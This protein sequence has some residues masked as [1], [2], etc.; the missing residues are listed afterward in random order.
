MI[1]HF[2]ITPLMLLLF[3][4]I[5]SASTTIQSTTDQHATVLSSTAQKLTIA[6]NTTDLDQQEVFL[7]EGAVDSFTIS[8]EGITYEYG[9]PVLPGVSRFVVVPPR[10]GLELIVNAGESRRIRADHQPV[11]CR[12]ENIAPLDR[13]RAPDDE[14][15]GLY[16]AV[17]AEMTEPLVIRGVRVVKVTTYPLQYDSDAGEYIH[18]PHIETE[19]RFTDDQPV[20]PVEYP[21]RRNRSRQFLRFIREL[22]INGN[23][24][25]RDDPDRDSEP[26]YVGH[27]LIVTHE[28][29]LEYAAPFIE[30][31]RKAGYKVDIFRVSTENALNAGIVSQA[32]QERY[33]AY[34]EDGSDP[35]EYILLIG[36]R[37]SYQFGPAAQWVLQAPNNRSDHLYACLEGNDDYPDVAISRWPSG[38][39]ET[40]ELAVGRTLAY[41]AEPFMED[42]AWFNRVAAYSQHWGYRGPDDNWEPSLHSNVRWGEEVLK[43]IGYQDIRFYETYEWDPRGELIG[44]YIRDLMNEGTN[45]HIGR[46]E[47][48]YFCDWQYG[49]RANFDEEVNDN[50]VFPIELGMC[51]HGERPRDL[52]FRTGSGE[53]LKGYV[54]TTYCWYTPPTLPMNVI[55]LELVRGVML[56]DLPLGWGFSLAITAW[57]GYMSD[58]LWGN[59]SAYLWVKNNC[60][61]LGDPAIQPWLG[62]PRVLDFE[63]PAVISSDDRVVEVHVFDPENDNADVKGAQVSLYA[64]G[65]IPEPDDEGYADYDGMFMVTKETDGAGLARFVFD[66]DASFEG[67]DVVYVTITGRDILPLFSEIEVGEPDEAVEIGEYTLVE[68]EGNDDGEVNPGEQFTLELTARNSGSMRLADVRGVV[69]SLS[70]W[71]EVQEN[72]IDFDGIDPGEEVG[73]EGEINLIISPLCPDG[74]SRPVT[75]PDLLVEFSDEDNSW[76]SGIRLNPVAPNLVVRQVVGGNVIPAG[77][78]EIDIE[79]ENVGGMDSPAL[80]AE[81]ISEG[82]D[83]LV[84]IDGHTGYGRV[85]SGR[86]ARI[87]GDC[88]IVTSNRMFIPGTRSD[89]LL[90]LRTEDGFVDSARFYLQTEEPRENAPQSPDNYGYICFDDTDDDWDMAPEYNWVEISPVDDDRDY[91]GTRIGFEGH[92]PRDMGESMVVELNMTTQFYGHEYDRITVATNGFIVMG[93]QE[94]IRNYQNWPLDRGIGGGLGMVAPFWDDLRFA[95]NS[96]VYYYLDQEEHRFIIEWYRLSHA[97][98]DNNLTFELM[99]YDKNFWITPTGDPMILFQYKTISNRPNVRE[100]DLEWENNT[101]YASVGISSPDEPTGISYTWKNEYPVTSAPLENRRAILFATSVMDF[102]AG[103]LYGRITDAATGEPIIGVAVTTDYGYHA[104]SDSVGYWSIG[105]AA[106]EVPFSITT[107]CHGYNNSTIAGLELAVDDTLEVNLALLHPEFH[108]SVQNIAMRLAPEDSSEFEFDIENRGNGELDWQAIKKLPEDADADPWEL[109][110]TYN[111]GQTVNDGRLEGV[112][113]F[114]DRFYVSGAN[115]RQPT[116]YI[117][118][119]QGALVDTFPQV[120]E[121]DR[122]IRDL[123]WDGELIWGCLDRNVYGFSPDGELVTN[124]ESPHNP[125]TT[126]TWDPDRELLWVSSTTTNITGI[127]RNGNQHAELNRCGLRIYGLAYWRDDPDEMPLYIFHRDRDS[128]RPT[129][130]KFNPENG[131]TAFVAYLEP[132]ADATPGGAFVTDEF[133]VY[134]WV[135][136]TLDNAT[137]NA[138]GDRVDV[139]QIEAHRDWFDLNLWAGQLDAGGVQPLALS[140][141]ASDL[142]GALY[143]GEFWFHHNAIGSP[144][145]IPVRLELDLPTPPSPFS[146]VSPEDGDTLNTIEVPFVW[147][148][149]SDPNLGDEV[150]Y[151]LWLKSENDSARFEVADA[152]LTLNLDTSGV[153]IDNE[154]PLCWRVQ[155]ISGLDTVECNA[156]FQFYVNTSEIGDPPLGQP[157]EFGLASIHPNPFNLVTT[158][159]Y[160]VDRPGEL[161]LDV[162]DHLGRKI[163]QLIYGNTPIGWHQVVWDA[164]KTASG[165][166][167]LRM[168]LHGRSSLAK[169]VLIK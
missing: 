84:V 139:W 33:D 142:R 55:W 135:F 6:F 29:C 106:T 68:T 71:I 27:Y 48:Y 87:E 146:L 132:G 118:D 80:N 163:D 166:Y 13:D 128:N 134:S 141:N 129:V 115:D 46:A 113:F 3:I 38:S 137:L 82:A 61:A 75:R 130:H 96:N 56:C 5:S 160:G 150:I 114:D 41:E 103:F 32:I 162:Y 19:I 28:N 57:E 100:G 35:F 90:I 108:P 107:S 157:V 18:H 148:V 44:P 111:V 45:L 74:G 72:E 123:A 88:F 147:E 62:V 53:H 153:A 169:V 42:P 76:R 24:V 149:S 86:T 119:L 47:N 11:L 26:E 156:S 152:Q 60:N 85:R 14:D 65:N 39:V 7:N 136:I 116:I 93:S 133:D 117:F 52:M 21:V 112:V 101:P 110:R 125:T 124:L 127:D 40:M 159:R 131:D 49:A 79:I 97:S 120:I 140:F 70:P 23:E 122:G 121:D 10:A 64:P 22:A 98:G 167:L 145:V 77:E 16:P 155:S 138:G 73:G 30:W 1:T 58:F 83:A 78:Q 66:E 54:A 69:T 12:D 144:T 31:R 9:R 109:R 104:R 143:L 99:L 20:N 91:D 67:Y 95:N 63:I 94:R 43:S 161:K 50:V 51:G 59:Q 8:D 168:E 105:E 102:R 34:I 154:Q 36:D 15:E 126:A 4:S 37:R 164:S 92:S 81:L 17:I 2:Q 158:V 25:G 89:M 151:N 165:V